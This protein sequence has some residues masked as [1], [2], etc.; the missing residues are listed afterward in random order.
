M[1]VLLIAVCRRTSCA[2]CISDKNECAWCEQTG[3]C[4]PFVAYMAKFSYGTCAE[5]VD[6]MSAQG[7][8][9]CS[10]QLSCARCL[11]DFGCGWCSD[12]SNSMLGQCL[13]GDFSGWWFFVIVNR[14]MPS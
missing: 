12:P 9:S 2:S 13:E 6:S 4:F 14:V 3:Q 1:S 7:C 10:Q 5:W 11:S 8:R